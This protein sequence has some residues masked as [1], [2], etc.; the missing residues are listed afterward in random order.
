MIARECRTG[1][2]DVAL[3]PDDRSREISATPER[4]LIAV[5]V[6]QV[7]NRLE[8][9]PLLF[10]MTITEAARIGSLP[11]RLHFDEADEGALHGDGIVGPCL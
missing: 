5:G 7:R 4:E 2:R 10:V 8:L 3:E 6:E 9:R 11:R 1:A